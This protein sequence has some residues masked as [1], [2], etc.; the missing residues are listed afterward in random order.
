MAEAEGGSSAPGGRLADLDTSV[1]HPARV[2][3]YWL[4]GQDNFAADREAAERVLAA[5][6]GLQYRVRA[7]CV[8]RRRAR[9]TTCGR[10]GA[11][12]GRSWT[13]PRTC[14]TS[15]SR[16]RSCCSGCCT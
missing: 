2:Y 11:I 4:G 9:P 14:W 16:W 13:R 8:A 12:P 6:P 5:A 15:A 3:D 7:C 10:T 1:A